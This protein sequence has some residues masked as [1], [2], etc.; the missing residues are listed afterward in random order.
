MPNNR[1]RIVGKVVSDK[2]QNTVVVAIENHKMHPMYHKVV[3]P[4][5][6]RSWRMMRPVRESARVVQ[7]RAKPTDK[8]TQA[9][10]R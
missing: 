6:G 10:G 5:R 1:K 7:H 9:L 3:S 8:Q 2:M 4:R